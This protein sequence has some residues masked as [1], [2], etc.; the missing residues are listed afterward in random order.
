MRFELKH[1]KLAARVS[2]RASAAAKA[3][4]RA[5]S[6]YRHYLD[7][8][9]LRL[10]TAQELQD[11]EG[12][13]TFLPPPGE[14]S[15]IIE[16]SQARF[17]ADQERER[18]RLE[19]ELANE[20]DLAHERSQR[21]IE[22]QRKARIM[23]V[24]TIAMALVA[25]VAGKLAIDIGATNDKLELTNNELESTLAREQDAKNKADRATRDTEAALATARK[26]EEKAN[27]LLADV[28]T[29]RDKAVTALKDRI[30]SEVQAIEA[31]A[32]RLAG[33]QRYEEAIKLLADAEQ[34][35][36]LQ[37]FRNGFSRRKADLESTYREY[38]FVRLIEA[39]ALAE[40]VQEYGLACKRLREAQQLKADDEE[41]KNKLASINACR[42]N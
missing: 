36:D 16:R 20:R 4:R 29:A 7:I 24:L 22:Q 10:L 41:V 26:L 38:R 11:L 1:D 2:E 32:D 9:R 42:E 12:Y 31:Q 6:A 25:L 8:G 27:H 35:P 33:Q 5:D 14:L 17:I 3:R 40:S 30:K 19:R 13:T 28:R 23:I 18:Q 37:Q 34:K 21:F 39:A 15:H